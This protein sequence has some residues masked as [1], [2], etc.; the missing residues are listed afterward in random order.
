MGYLHRTVCMVI[1][2]NWWRIN[3]FIICL[4]PFFFECWI[5]LFFFPLIKFVR[6]KYT[7]TTLDF[8]E[9]KKRLEYVYIHITP[10]SI[11]IEVILL[12]GQISTD[13]ISLTH[14]TRPERPSTHLAHS[15]WA[16][17]YSSPDRLQVH[18]LSLLTKKI[19]L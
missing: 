19:N 1:M 16:L 9:P 3:L 13:L 6:L 7:Y 4:F 18:S 15:H 2:S 8:L 14:F 10:L 12:H 11:F 5:T 17:Y